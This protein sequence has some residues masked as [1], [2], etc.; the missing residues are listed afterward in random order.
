[1]LNTDLNK[2]KKSN[3]EITRKLASLQS[4]SEAKV[5]YDFCTKHECLFVVWLN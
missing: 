3:E 4:L 1:M 2:V 5:C